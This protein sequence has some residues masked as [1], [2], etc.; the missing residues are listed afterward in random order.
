M[1][2]GT[3]DAESRLARIERLLESR[4]REVAPAWRRVTRGEPR[5]AVTAVILV[6]VTLQLTVPHDLTLQPYWVLPALELV[7][8]AGLIVAN[9]GGWSPGAGGCAGWAWL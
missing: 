7:L 5:W 9:P 2:D 6:A 3:N 4:E 8:L 1:T